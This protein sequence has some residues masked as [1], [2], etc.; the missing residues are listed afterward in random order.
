MLQVCCTSEKELE[1]RRVGSEKGLIDADNC[2]VN[3]KPLVLWHAKAFPSCTWDQTLGK[4]RKQNRIENSNETTGKEAKSDHQEQRQKRNLETQRETHRS[5]RHS[6]LSAHFNRS[7]CRIAISVKCFPLSFGPFGRHSGT[8]KPEIDKDGKSKIEEVGGHQF[9]TALL[10]LPQSNVSPSK[11]H[12]SPNLPFYSHHHISIPLQSPDTTFNRIFLWSPQ[13]VNPDAPN[14]TPQNQ[15][16]ISHPHS[17]PPEERSDPRKR[18]GNQEELR[19]TKGDP[20]DNWSVQIPFIC[21]ATN[22]LA[23]FPVSPHSPAPFFKEEQRGCKVRR[24]DRTMRRLQSKPASSPLSFLALLFLV[25]SPFRAAALPYPLQLANR[26][27]GWLVSTTTWTETNTFTSTIT[28]PI[29][30]PTG[31]A[32]E[33][34][35]PQEP[36]WIP[37]G[38]VCCKS[39]QYCA[40]WGQCLDNEGGGGGGIISTITTD[41]HTITTRYSAPFRVTSATSTGDGAASPTNTPTGTPTAIPSGPDDGDG[42]TAGGG[43]SP[44]AIAGIVI[45][46]LAGISLLMLL[47]FCC[48]VRGLWGLICGGRKRDDDR[49]RERVDVV[50]ERYHGGGRPPSTYTGRDRHSRWFGSGPSS[51]ANRRDEEKRDSTGAKWWGLGA[52]AATLLALLHL[53]RRDGDKTKGPAR[54][55]DRD[56]ARDRRSRSRYTDSYYTYTDSE[57]SWDSRSRRTYLTS[58]LGSASSG[59]R[60]RQDGRGSSRNSNSSS[61]ISMTQQK[62]MTATTNEITLSLEAEAR[63][64]RRAEHGDEGEEDTRYNGRINDDRKWNGN[65]DT[66][67]IIASVCLYELI[68]KYITHLDM[69][70]TLST[71]PFECDMAHTNNRTQIWGLLKISSQRNLIIDGIR[72]EMHP[73]SPCV[74]IGPQVV[75]GSISR[76]KRGR[77]DGLGIWVK[78]HSGVEECPATPL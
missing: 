4:L 33:D 49:R 1:V 31:A 34:C 10:N 23:L 72:L 57:S 25:A 56:R 12:L 27:G 30:E 2:P 63:N 6:Y 41:G 54:D 24:P 67:A 39:S 11:P 29:S 28:K 46:T 35:V 13:T 44:G 61:I 5:I 50:E 3:E 45:G 38:P 73:W 55:R 42:G 75:I 74:R 19:E 51:A 15:S 16:T 69:P 66:T 22:L 48:I 78:S 18:D 64:C 47:C 53:R 8:G 40:S 36:G 7:P 32:G 9:L 62:K 71:A 59:G 14:Q 58:Y 21:S 20:A 43:L 77:N 26:D 60:T 76:S 52:I 17:R 65:H 37:C 68:N 70:L